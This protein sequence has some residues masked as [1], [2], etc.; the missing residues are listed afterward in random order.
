MLA[1]VTILVSE[2]KGQCGFAPY[3]CVDTNGVNI[4]YQCPGNYTYDP[5]CG[6]DGNTYINYCDMRNRHGVCYEQHSGPC[7]T[8]RFD[9]YPTL[10]NQFIYLSAMINN[11][12]NGLAEI[13]DAFGH[14]MFSQNFRL[15][16]SFDKLDQYQIDV[17]QYELGMYFMIFTVGGEGGVMKFVKVYTE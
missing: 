10:T 5:Q 3:P 1:M 2:A 6:C 14:K 12:G 13:Y 4:Y 16:D 15:Y 11:G 8:Y 17:S 9:I 7:G